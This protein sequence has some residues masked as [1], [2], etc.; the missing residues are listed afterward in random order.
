M[1]LFCI[2]INLLYHHA[3]NIVVLSGLRFLAATWNCYISYKNIY[4]GLFVLHLLPLLNFAHRQNV[5][6]L[7]FFYRYCF[8]RCL[9]ELF[10]LLP[11][12]FFWGRSTCYSDTLHDFSATLPR[13]YKN[14]YVNSLFPSTSRL[15]N[16]RLIEC[17]LLTYDLNGFKSRINR[18]PLTIVSF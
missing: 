10:Q 1:R 15:L 18:H 9:S 7:S 3:W 8:G 2:S 6:S 14:V 5:A 13:C 16:S 4:A 11:L 17:F 12:P